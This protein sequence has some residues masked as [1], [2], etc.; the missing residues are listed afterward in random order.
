MFFGGISDSIREGSGLSAE[1]ELLN[2]HTFCYNVIEESVL[3]KIL[4]QATTQIMQL[5]LSCDLKESKQRE[6]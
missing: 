6:L 4:W 3:P 2:K 1:G 5:A